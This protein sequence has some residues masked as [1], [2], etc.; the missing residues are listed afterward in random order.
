MKSFTIAGSQLAMGASLGNSAIW[1]HTKG[2][3]AIERIFL[4]SIAKSFVGTVNVRYAGHPEHVDPCFPGLFAAGRHRRRAIPMFC[5]DDRLSQ[6]HDYV[7]QTIRFGEMFGRRA[8]KVAERRLL[9]LRD[10]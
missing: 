3:G 4:N 6:A 8:V 10:C 9:K 5:A 2:D 7:C 1:I